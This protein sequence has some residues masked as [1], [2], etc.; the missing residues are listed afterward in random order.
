MNIG[1]F[2]GG[3]GLYG[4]LPAAIHNGFKVQT[5]SKYKE[6][7]ESRSDISHYLSEINF[8]DT[9][10][11]LFDASKSIVIARNPSSQYQLMTSSNLDDKIF[12]LEKPLATSK[13]LHTKFLKKLGRNKT[14]FKIAYIFLY[15]EWYLKI[16]ALFKTNPNIIININWMVNSRS[17]GWKTNSN[18][19]GGIAK[20]YGIHFLPL[21]YKFQISQ[22]DIF[23]S[24]ESP[25]KLLIKANLFKIKVSIEENSFFEVEVIEN[26]KIIYSWDGMNPFSKEGIS[27]NYTDPR[28]ELLEKHLSSKIDNS[29]SQESVELEEFVVEVLYE[30]LLAGK[31]HTFAGVE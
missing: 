18:S 10:L 26:G 11:E 2:G 21:L 7:I 9:E 3:F 31:E 14:L 28:I 13:D 8:F 27:P 15:T 6:I 20:F 12:F 30:N 25:S 5:L 19:G 23:C 29:S 4:Y 1:I 22:K 24:I 17:V 16:L